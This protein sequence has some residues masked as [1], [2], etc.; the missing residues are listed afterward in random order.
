MQKPTLSIIAGPN[1]SGKTTLTERF[2]GHDWGRGTLYIN[3]DAIAQNELGGWNDVGSIRQAMIIANERRA[4]ALENGNSLVFETV[5]SAP[6]KLTF[7]TK[8]KQA[9]YF[10]RLFFV[11]TSSPEINAARVARRVMEG[12]HTVPIEK[13]ISRYAKSILNC[14]QA[15]GGV[16]RL[17]VYDNSIDDAPA[18]LLFR[19]AEGRLI[20]QYETNLAWAQVVFQ[21]LLS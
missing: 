10:I 2:L 5:F 15:A 11:G 14:A 19:A 6:E 4:K 13:I 9:G 17:Y 3:P 21:A 18:R 20:K 7:L 16:D 8:A 12:G 1:G